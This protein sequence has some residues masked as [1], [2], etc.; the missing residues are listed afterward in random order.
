MSAESL[1]ID[2]G[3]NVSGCLKGEPKLHPPLRFTYRPCLAAERQ[4]WWDFEERQDRAPNPDPAVKS[5]RKIEIM[6]AH[7]VS[8]EACDRSGRPMPVD[9]QALARLHPNLHDR[10]FNVILGVVPPDDAP[11]APR[12][13]P[14][15]GAAA[16]NSGT[17]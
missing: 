11:D 15:E 3:Y 7:I 2:D 6:A 14:D 4:A 13:T 16:K 17:R 8:W 12:T 1:F 9:A 10:L 5:R